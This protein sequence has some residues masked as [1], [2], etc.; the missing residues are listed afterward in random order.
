MSDKQTVRVGG[1]TKLQGTLP[2]DEERRNRPKRSW[3]P[4][5]ARSWTGATRKE[6]DA[7]H[8]REALGLLG[9]QRSPIQLPS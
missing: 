6:A 3:P 2:L 5:S 9:G 4:S 1:G 7:A 8:A